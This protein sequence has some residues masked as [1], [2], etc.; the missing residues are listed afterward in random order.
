MEP[1]SGDIL[2]TIATENLVQFRA[3]R[4]GGISKMEV[5]REAVLITM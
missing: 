5:I 1:Q 3:E 2:D 4:C